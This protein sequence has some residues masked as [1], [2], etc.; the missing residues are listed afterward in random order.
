MNIMKE[1]L[2]EQPE[3]VKMRMRN[4]ALI[5]NDPQTDAIDRMSAAFAL[6]EIGGPLIM[7]SLRREAE[8][9]RN[10]PPKYEMRFV[11]GARVKVRVN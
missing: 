4:L 2:D 11:R 7:E 9:L 10:A 6:G 8:Q 5:V 1:V 3:E